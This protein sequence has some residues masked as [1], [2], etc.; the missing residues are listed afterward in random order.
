MR[1]FGITVVKFI[2]AQTC[3]AHFTRLPLR[4]LARNHLY[5]ERENKCV[6]FVLAEVRKVHI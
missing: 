6:D 3:Y 1:R 4:A 5:P 2:V